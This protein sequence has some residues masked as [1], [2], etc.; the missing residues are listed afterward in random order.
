MKSRNWVWMSMLWCTVAV[1]PVSGLLFSC[2][3]K[4]PEKK[5]EAA[6]DTLRVL[7]FNILYGGDE[8]NFDKVVEVITRS[9]ADLAGIQEAEG[10][11][12]KLAEA[13]G[14]KYYDERTH[15]ISRYPVFG[16]PEGGRM[17]V[18]VMVRPGKVV[19]LANL[20]LPSD[21]Y[22][23]EQMLKG[24]APDSIRRL[25]ASLRMP[26]LTP[27]L[28]ALPKLVQQGVPVFL[29][30]DFNTPSHQD[31]TEAAVNL[32]PQIKEA[33][34]WPITKSLTDAGFKDAY[35][36]FYPDP[37]A[38]PGLTWTPGY[39]PPH[40][41]PA[42]THDRIDYIWISEKISVIDV[43]IIGEEGGK[44]VDVAVSPYA[45]DHRAVMATCVT[46]AVSPPPFTGVWPRFASDSVEI[47]FAGF[48]ASASGITLTKEGS[49]Q[50]LHQFA[51]DPSHPLPIR[52]GWSSP[53]AGA[54]VVRVLDRRGNEL[55][56]NDFF[57]KTP[58]S[59]PFVAVGQAAYPVGA[60]IIVR[61]EGAPGFK[62]D[63]IAIYPEN[64][65]P[66]EDYNKVSAD[67]RYLMYQYTDA[68][69][70]GS[71]QI[72]A[73]SLGETWPLKPGKYRAHLLVD[74]GF[75]TLASA[76]FTVF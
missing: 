48:D 30:G 2:N 7:T 3:K 29:T 58:D 18:Y 73:H 31:Y 51:I 60:P 8:Y 14:W 72:D 61:W 39:P 5:E 28:D 55:A 25:E 4:H 19:A 74:D 43:K 1:C 69:I 68:Q 36:T 46:T 42:E 13:A 75:V 67:C 38:K 56:R 10:N 27:Y 40:V 15:I 64:A 32:R 33:F 66:T 22:G 50:P 16:P 76:P 37:V 57:V 21:P 20:H 63:W 6:R 17:Y 44:D 65:D 23:P 35:R 49:T 71:L 70:G 54:Y 53:Q 26:T 45:S 52:L 24:V 9:G 12:K 59:K 41:S 62:Y 11:L 34:A 47:G